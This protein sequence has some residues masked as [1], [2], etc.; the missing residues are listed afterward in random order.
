MLSCYGRACA[1]ARANSPQGGGLLIPLYRLHASRLRLALDAP[2]LAAA[3]AAQSPAL[4]ARVQGRVQGLQQQQQGMQPEQAARLL[5]QLYQAELQ[6][7]EEGQLADILSCVSVHWFQGTRVAEAS[8]LMLQWEDSWQQAAAELQLFY[9]TTAG[10]SSG[11]AAL[12]QLRDLL[13]ADACVAMHWIADTYCSLV[14]GGSGSQKAQYHRARYQLAYAA[15]A[16]GNAAG[17]LEELSHL[18]GPTGTG[19]SHKPVAILISAVQDTEFSQEQQQQEGG[20]GRKRRKAGRYRGGRGGDGRR[21]TTS[22]R[23]AADPSSSQ[24][25]ADRMDG[26]DGGTQDVGSQDPGSQPQWAPDPAVESEW[27]LCPVIVAGIGAC[28]H[29]WVLNL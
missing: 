7:E 3:A 22:E 2:R 24:A 6:H 25:H 1:L 10:Q 5:Q 29:I 20:G 15:M 18:I 9:R 19:R 8:R 23:D 4:T 28:C 11:R 26:D 16:Q 12:G 21:R 27:G 17:A 14:P 13:I